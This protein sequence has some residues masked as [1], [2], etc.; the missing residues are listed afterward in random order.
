MTQNTVPQA[1]APRALSLL[2]RLTGA[3]FS[4]KPTFESVSAYPVWV[5]VLA[6]TV[7]LT[8]LVWFGF[9]S[10]E[11][12]RQAFTDQQ[13]QQAEAWG[14]TITP[15]VEQSINAQAPV[16]R[17]VIPISTLVM[18]PLFVAIIAGVLYGVFAA[19]LGG[20]ATYKQTLAVVVHA[21]VVSTL[22]FLGTMALN[23]VRGSMSSATNLGVFVQ[24]L[25]EDSFLVRFLGM[26]D[27][28]WVWYLIVLAI[29]LGVLYRRKTSTVAM[30]L[31]AVYLVVALGYVGVR[32]AL[33]GS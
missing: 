32:S 26:I 1:G 2:E 13:F 5:D 9:M 18:G 19:V 28:V 24:M 21:G 3:I 30:G 10:T 23:F 27:L 15:Q 14:T 7:L 17:W 20:G 25:P 31:F 29:G 8:S 33:G 22:G 4:P 16:M 12:G 11:S 6:V